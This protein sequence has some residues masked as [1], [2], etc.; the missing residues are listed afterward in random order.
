MAVGLEGAA[1]GSEDEVQ[2]LRGLSGSAK[3]AAEARGGGLAV[4]VDELRYTCENSG[5]YHKPLL[6]AW[7]GK[8]S[9]N[10]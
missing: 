3:E 4:G 8:P 2:D 10:N 9:V 6:K 1:G 5:P 7:G